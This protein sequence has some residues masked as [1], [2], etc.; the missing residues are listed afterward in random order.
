[1]RGDS[2]YKSRL[3]IL[4]SVFILVNLAIISSAEER[5]V[6]EDPNDWSVTFIDGDSNL[7]SENS[8]AFVGDYINLII[9]VS[10]SDTAAG[11]DEW[12]FFMN[13]DG[14]TSPNLTGFLDGAENQIEVNITFGPLP[15]GLIELVLIIDSSG[16]S[17]SLFLP[18]EPNPL[19]LTAAGAAEV[20]L[21]GEPIHLGDDLTASI[22]VHNQGTSPQIMNLELKTES[23]IISSGNHVEINPGSS[24]EVSALISPDVVGTSSIEWSVNC[25]NGGVARE[26]NGSFSVEVLPPQ[27]M[28]LVFDST[29]WDLANGL[30]VDISLY[31]SEGRS[32]DVEIEVF[33]LDQTIESSVQTFQLNLNPG[34][35]SISLSLGEPSADAMIVQINALDW[36]PV[37]EL[38]ITHQLTPP[39]L[40]LSIQFESPQP[41]NPIIGES[42]ILP[43]TLTNLGNTPTLSGEIRVVRTSDGMIFDSM[44]TPVVNSG[45]SV[46]GQ[47]EI[48]SWPDSSRIDVELMWITGSITEISLVEITSFSQND[49]GFEAPFDIK[50]AIYGS[51]FGLVLVL[52]ILVVYRTLSEDVENTGQS[53]FNKIRE[54]RGVKKKA[55]IATKK[56]IMCPECS[57]RLSIPTSHS[58]VVKCPACTSRF[59]VEGN[60][61]ESTGNTPIHSSAQPSN[62]HTEPPKES[63]NELISR[64][65]DDLLSCPSCEQTLRVP[66][67]KRPV[68]ARCP[69]CRSEFIAEEGS[70][71]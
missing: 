6:I 27:S 55:A 61:D 37:S 21:I 17:E 52:F 64:S 7:P 39:N 32:R 51:V 68:K 45:D 53:R 9:E 38:E 57:Q 22:L 12:I 42:V 20:A 36:T 31:L 43:Y 33:F 5:F 50:A 44:P 2:E 63:V 41:E 58:G 56:E 60:S 23:G 49:D 25:S 46:S 70:N 4:V 47:L 66:L 14:L 28:E 40:E 11:H 71:E 29:Q 16:V 13:I 3:A 15:E 35:R 48:K 1:M 19:N 30:N 8:S 26:L 59:T 67:D 24:R 54:A 18:I 65:L 34:R 69:A 62:Q 10:N